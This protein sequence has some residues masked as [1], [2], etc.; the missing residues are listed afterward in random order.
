[1]SCLKEQTTQHYLGSGNGHGCVQ[2]GE[3]LV[4][5]VF[6]TTK[7]VNGRLAQTAFKG[8]DLHR[9]KVSLC[10]PQIH[11]AADFR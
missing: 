9:G 2:P 7:R 1:M 4:L 11:H 8:A 6:D 10:R 5:A 3:V